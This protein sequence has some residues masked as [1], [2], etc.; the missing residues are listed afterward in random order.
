MK[1]KLMRTLLTGM[2]STC[3]IGTGIIAGTMTASAADADG[4]YIGKFADMGDANCDG[5][6]NLADAVI[7]MQ[8]LANAPKYGI[9]GTDASHLTANGAANAD[10][11]ERGNGL[12]NADA[13]S[14][15]KKLL[16]LIQTFPESFAAD[17]EEKNAAPQTTTTTLPETT[18]TTTTTAPETTTT[19]TESTTT[20]TESTTTTTTTTTTSTTTTT[21]STTTTT[22]TTSKPVGQKITPT[23]YM[24]AVKANFNSNVP[25]DVKQGDSGTTTKITYYSKKAQRDKPANVWLPPNYSQNEKYPV[26]Y[27]NHGVMGGE[28]DMLNGWGIREM[29]SNLIK[30]GE[31]KPFIIVFTQMYTD[32]KSATCSGITQES[33]DRY[34]DFLYDLT[35]SLMPY[36]AEHY[37]V[38]EG[39]ENTAIA[40]F[41]MGGRESLYIGIMAA[42]KI[43]YV[44]AS[45]PAPGAVPGQDMFLNHRGSM[46]ESEFKFS[47]PNIPYLLMIGGG[48]NDSVVGT[49]PKQYSE[50]LK[51]NGNDNI[52]FEVQGA[53]HDA[54]VG[55]PLFYNFFR[56]LF[57]TEGGFTEGGGNLGEGASV[58]TG[59]DQ[60]GWNMGGDQGGWNFGGDQGG[61]NF[62]GDQGGWN[63]GGDQ[64]G[65]NFGGDQGGF[66]FGDMGGFDWSAFGG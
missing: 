54:G 41:S 7:I 32:P 5:K 64:G 2:I 6:I 60:G 47:E 45:S 23:E 30:K 12:T 49:F 28:G 56:N 53:G 24:A 29:A 13:L 20:T 33:M 8:S 65:W 4:D 11:C 37:S 66:N 38:A 58:S 39:R 59:G 63:F 25:A 9:E 36:M 15:Q 42:D 55:T 17:Y 48:T 51:K 3:V 57:K 52:W 19:T 14:I 34:D 10:V 35:E 44:C 1:K 40:G 43:G 50:L 62:G 61:W 18:T 16:D 31:V 46:S 27:M 21:E 22:T 26:V